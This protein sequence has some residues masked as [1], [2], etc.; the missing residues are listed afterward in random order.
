MVVGATAHVPIGNA[1]K[2]QNAGP[3][4]EHEGKRFGGHPGRRGDKRLRGQSFCHR[5]LAQSGAVRV[6]LHFVQGFRHVENFCLALVGVRRIFKGFLQKFLKGMS[7][8]FVAEKAGRPAKIQRAGDD[9]VLFPGF[10]VPQGNGKAGKRIHFPHAESIELLVQIGEAVH[11]IIGQIRAGTVTKFS[12]EPHLKAQPSCHGGTGENG[13]LAGG[14]IPAHMGGVAAINGLTRSPDRA[15]DFGCRRFL[16][17]PVQN[18]A[19][20]F[21]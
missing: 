17:P 3:Q 2:S 15:G 10:Y 6:I 7:G 8:L 9:V 21:L 18:R 12:L 5:F 19:G 4:L 13:Y 14:D 16:L 11:G 20:F 1:G